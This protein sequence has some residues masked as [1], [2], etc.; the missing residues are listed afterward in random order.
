MDG[1]PVHPPSTVPYPLLYWCCT[2]SIAYP[3]F[4]SILVY[5]AYTNYY[6]HTSVRTPME[7]L[8]YSLLY[9]YL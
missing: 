9:H 5:V 3:L 2:A 4:I 1:K 8:P 6:Y 7:L